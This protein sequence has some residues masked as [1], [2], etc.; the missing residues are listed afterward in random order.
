MKEWQSLA[1]AK[2]ERRYHAATVP[3]YRRKVPYG[4][5]RRRT[6]EILRDLC[7]YKG[8]ET[9]EAHAVADHIHMCI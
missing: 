6:G 2:R 3:K 1:Q 4:K 5:L 7:R 9:A 8:I